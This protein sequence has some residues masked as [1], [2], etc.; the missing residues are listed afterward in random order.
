MG[1]LNPHFLPSSPSFV[2]IL[3]LIRAGFARA[4]PFRSRTIFVRP[5]VR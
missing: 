3:I 1:R 2:L 5:L 4:Y